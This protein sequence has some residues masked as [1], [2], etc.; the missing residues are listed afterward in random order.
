MTQTHDITANVFFF[1]RHV[2]F[3]PK[4]T[5]ESELIKRGD[6]SGC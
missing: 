3:T 5:L 2:F 6:K 1:V 4:D